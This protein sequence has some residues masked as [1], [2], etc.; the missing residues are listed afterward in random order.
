MQG[1]SKLEGVSHLIV[2]EVH[3]RNLDDDF[4]LIILRD[5]LPFRPDLK[6]VCFYITLQKY[7]LF[8]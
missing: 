8:R 2:D 3:E 1:H 5:L 7:F 4:L 6:V